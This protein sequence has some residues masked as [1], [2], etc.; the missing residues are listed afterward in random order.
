MKKL[1]IAI[2]GLGTVGGGVYDILKENCKVIS[3]KNNVEITVKKIFGRR[4]RDDVPKELFTLDIDEIINDKEI[5]AVVETLGGIDPAKEFVVKALKSGKHVV[6][7]NKALLASYWEELNSIANENNVM[8]LFEASVGGGI[9][10]ISAL[11]GNLS[12][13]NFVEVMGIVNGTT[14]YILTKM[15]EGMTYDEALNEAKE[16]GFA[17]ANPIADVDGIDAANKL[18]ILM[19]L[20]FDKAVDPMSIPRCG[21]RHLTQLDIAEAD[22]KK[23]KIK[24]IAHAWLK[25]GELKCSVKPEG[26]PNDHPLAGVSNEF[27]AIYIVGDKVGEVMLYGK[28]AGAYPTG[29]AVVGD[30]IEITKKL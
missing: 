15:T 19:A 7:A 6:T 10:V 5:D 13:N 29:S 17:E 8:L 18:S 26:I 25:D 27:N 12:G 9:P 20:M 30:L 22:M 16:K 1:K 21:I 2:L 24:L 11:K 3:N 28:G 14:N 4:H 23:K